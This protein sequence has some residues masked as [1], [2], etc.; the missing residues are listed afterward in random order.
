MEEEIIKGGRWRL[1][2]TSKLV[3]IDV[4]KAV[5]SE[6]QKPGADIIPSSGNMLTVSLSLS[7]E[8][9]GQG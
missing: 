6:E 1:L 8:K 2:E 9:Q 3:D 7:S 5:V 4:T